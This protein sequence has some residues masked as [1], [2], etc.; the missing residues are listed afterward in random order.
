MRSLQL[1]PK[2]FSDL[3]TMNP[4]SKEYDEDEAGEEIKRGLDQFDNNPKP[5]LSET[6]VVNLG[7]LKEMK[8]I[9]M[10]I[11]VKQNIRDDIIQVLIEYKD[12]FAWSYDDMPGLS[13]DL[14][15][16]KLP[17]HLDFPHVQQK[18]RKFK[19]N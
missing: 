13:A 15:V 14:V 16:H 7:T 1:D 12:V 11:H 5:N 9:K 3:I 4:K 2:K 6:E 10:S 18:H 17:I 19:T 8:E